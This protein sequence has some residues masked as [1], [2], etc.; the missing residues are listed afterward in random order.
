[1]KNSLSLSLFRIGFFFTIFFL[2]FLIVYMVRLEFEVIHGKAGFFL[3]VVKTIFALPLIYFS[4][5]GLTFFSKKVKEPDQV[6]IS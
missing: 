1:M 6:V 2:T 3:T 5:L 4:F